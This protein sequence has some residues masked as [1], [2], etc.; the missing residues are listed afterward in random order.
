MIELDTEKHAPSIPSIE[1]VVM[2]C[3]SEREYWE[4]LGGKVE[5]KVRRDASGRVLLVARL[6]A[7]GYSAPECADVLGV[8]QMSVSRARS[9]L[10]AILS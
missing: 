9:S 10:A 6:L 7:A 8:S 1:H 4:G 3:E 5:G 2:E